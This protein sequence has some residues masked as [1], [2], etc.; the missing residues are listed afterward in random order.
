VTNPVALFP[1]DN[2]GVVLQFPA[3]PLGIG[4]ASVN[5]TLTFGIGT[6]S[7]S[8]TEANNTPPGTVKTYQANPD[9]QFPSQPP[10]Q[11]DTTFAGDGTIAN[12]FIDSGSNALFFPDASLAN[13]TDQQ[14]QPTD[15]YCPASA[16]SLSATNS[17]ISGSASAVVN[18]TI[19]NLANESNANQSSTVFADMGGGTPGTIGNTFDWGLPFFLGRTVY[20]GIQGKSSPLL[21]TPGNPYWGY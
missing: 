16:Q 19:G 1:I 2:N 6:E 21:T 12:G 9:V 5:G 3:V 10:L 18:F 15:F 11:F 13:C 17:G 4:A 20:V 7:G 8:A 14:G